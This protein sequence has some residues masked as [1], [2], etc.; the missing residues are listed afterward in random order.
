MTCL[1]PAGHDVGMAGPVVTHLLLDFFGTLVSYSPSRTEQGYHA[2]YALVRSMGASVDYPGFLQAWAAESA[3]FDER[4]DVDDSEFSMD[5]VAAAYLTR[6]LRRDPD[7]P[8]I[9]MFVEAYLSEWN[10]GVGYPPDIAELVGALAGSFRL[11]VVTN[12][13][14][15]DLVPGHLSAMGIAHH[16]DAVV[17]SVEVGWR[18]PHPAIYATA[19]RRLGI[20]AQNAVFTGDSHAADY[21]GPVAAGMTA[22]LIDPDEQSGVPAD[23]RL[24]S[25]HDLP[26]RLAIL[27]NVAQAAAD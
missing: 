9:S 8:Q 27:Q 16:F 19:L 11:G 12:T 6:T 13:H 23:R 2:T 26:E 10:S 15:A 5:Q 3:L 4:S 7:P 24:R 17:T 1:W 22:F 25:L 21:A 18:K 20:I 14:H